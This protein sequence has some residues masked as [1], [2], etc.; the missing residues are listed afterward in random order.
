MRRWTKERVRDDE[1]TADGR[2]ISDIR[3]GLGVVE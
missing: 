2:N 3:A 1:T